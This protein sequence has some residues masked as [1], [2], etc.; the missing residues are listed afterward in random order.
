MAFG[1]KT[2]GT[3]LGDAIN[4]S[5]VGPQNKNRQAYYGLAKMGQAAPEPETQ[6]SPW[7]YAAGGLAVGSL[8]VWLLTR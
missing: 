2:P 8:L 1:W 5:A 4:P 7:W 6:L 3:K